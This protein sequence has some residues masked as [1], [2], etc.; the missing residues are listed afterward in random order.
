MQDV[1]YGFQEGEIDNLELYG[2]IEYPNTE[3]DSPNDPLAPDVELQRPR[4][5]FTRVAT[6]PTTLD[7]SFSPQTL[8]VA[9]DSRATLLRG[10]NVRRV[11]V[12]IWV[13]DENSGLVWISHQQT[14]TAGAA[15][16]AVLLISPVT[17]LEIQAPGEIYAIIDASATESVNV[18]SIE[19]TRAS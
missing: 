18:Y 19:E 12:R 17:P 16:G 6:K 9:P 15:G 10:R 14:A 7:A 4:L 11:R 13:D 5:F 8:S 3:Q 2:A 1:R